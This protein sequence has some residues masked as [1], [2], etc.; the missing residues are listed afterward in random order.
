MRNLNYSGRARR[1]KVSRLERL[2][3]MR[4]ELYK[5][6]DLIANAGGA[7]SVSNAHPT[8]E[9]ISEGIRTLASV[10]F[11]QATATKD[12]VMF[13]K[14]FYAGDATLKTGSAVLSDTDQI[15]AL[16]MYNLGEKTIDREAYF[17][18][19]AT[20]KKVRKYVF[21][22]N[23]NQLRITFRDGLQEIDEYAFYEAKNAQYYDFSELTTL[24]KISNYA[25]T[26]SGGTGLDVA[27]LPNCIQTLNSS[28]FAY[29][30]PESLD[31]RFPDSLTSM[32][33]SVFK[34][35]FRK[36]VNSLDLSNV[37]MATLNSYTF[38]NVGFNC[39]FELPS[40]V[41]TVGSYFNQSGT[42]NNIRIPATCTNLQT[43]C[44]G[45]NTTY[46]ID[47]FRLQTV[48]FESETPPVFG[49][50]VFATQHV[51]NNFKIYVPDNAV[52]AYKAVDNLSPYV[53]HIFP[54][55]QKL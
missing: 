28:A 6:K 40:I 9:E 15:N 22:Q 37:K 19:P 3:A 48:T 8:M 2:K 20:Q 33:Q 42:F 27:R 52:E 36:E 25:F 41:T 29:V 44:F 13:G 17:T 1:L 39:D 23:I 35:D 24:K 18:I 5:Q 38:Q 46:P 51:R 49:T 10:D 7:V 16:F 4:E 26:R 43:E 50:K 45:S 30:Q 11:A 55:S 34:Q 47:S 21:F 12:D 14:T 31:Y 54:M 32:G 53:D